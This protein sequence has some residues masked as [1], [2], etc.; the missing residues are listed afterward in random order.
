MGKTRSCYG[1]TPETG[2]RPGC[3]GTCEKYKKDKADK[4][5]EKA[6]NVDPS[7]HVKLFLMDNCSAANRKY[8]K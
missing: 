4:E 7:L 3:H 8:K 1:C 2:R 5:A 6:R